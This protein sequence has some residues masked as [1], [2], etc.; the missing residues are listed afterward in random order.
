LVE[1]EDV[2]EDLAKAR[3]SL[4]APMDIYIYIY[5]HFFFS[6][7]VGGA[8]GCGGGFGEGARQFSGSHGLKVLAEKSQLRRAQEL[9]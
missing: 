6:P 5:M 4:V 2:E 9:V 1:P 7:G 3:G 8:G